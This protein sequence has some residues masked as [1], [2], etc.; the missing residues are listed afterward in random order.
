M[1]IRRARRYQSPALLGLCFGGFGEAQN[2]HR[3]WPRLQIQLAYR[4]DAE[5]NYC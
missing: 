2:H 4:T 1:T 5:R 3:L